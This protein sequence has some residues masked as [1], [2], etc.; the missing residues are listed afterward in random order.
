MARPLLF[1]RFVKDRRAALVELCNKYRKVI[2][3]LVEVS[4]QSSFS[5]RIFPTLALP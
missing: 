5:N 2:N 1:I 4:Y 3:A